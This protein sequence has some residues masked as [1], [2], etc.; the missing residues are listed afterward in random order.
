MQ[1]LETTGER[2][3]EW[4]KFYIYELFEV[5]PSKSYKGL[6]DSV[7]I[8]V[9]GKTP[10]VSNQSRNNGYIGW[11]NLEPLNEGNVITLSDTWQSERTIF[12]QPKEFIGKSHLQVM[13]YRNN[14]FDKYIA[15]FIISTFR[16]AILDMRY[17]YGMKFN[18]E[19]IKNTKI[20][21]PVGDDNKPDFEFMKLLIFSTQKIVIKNVVEWLDKRIQATKQVISK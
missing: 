17:D 2:Q 6:N 7:I 5:N 1:R 9:N 8:N 11:S 12:Y 19:R 18:R 14:N 4:H 20:C 13:K 16:K 15:W 3:I 10:Y 21:L